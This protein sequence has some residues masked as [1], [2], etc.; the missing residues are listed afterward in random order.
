ML[1]QLRLHN[2][3]I[4]AQADVTFDG[5]FTVI[6]GETGSG[7]SVM[8]E[9]IALAFGQK[10]SPK[11][12][13]RHGESRGLVELHF[14]RLPKL[15]S[16]LCEQ[17]GLEEQPSE[18]L[19]TRE[20]S[21]T[22]SRYRV[23]G[24][25]VTG[26]LVQQLR[27]YLVDLHGQHELTSLFQPDHHRKLL[28][29]LGNSDFQ[30]L[31]QDYKTLHHTWRHTCQEITRLEA[32]R[33]EVLKQRDFYQFQFEALQKAELTDGEEDTRLRTQL[34]KLKQGEALAHLCQQTENTLLTGNDG[35]VIEALETLGQAYRQQA[36]TGDAEF[37]Q[38]QEQLAAA[39]S[40]LREVADG[41]I[42]YGD[43]L[44]LTAED[45]DAAVERLDV[46]ERIRR[47]FGPTLEAAITERD[48]LGQWLQ[49][50]D[51]TNDDIELLTLKAQKQ[52]HQL[53]EWADQ[54]TKHRQG[55]AE[56]LT[57]GIQTQLAELALP[58][59][60]FEVA[61]AVL[62]RLEGPPKL[63]EHGQDKVDFTFS[64]N[65]GE[66]LRPLQQVASGG[67]LSRVLLA[68]KVLVA[69]QANVPTLVFDEIDTGISGPTARAVAAKLQRMAET[70]V[71]VLCITHQP[72]VA[73]AGQHHI[74]VEKTFTD[75]TVSVGIRPLAADQRKQLLV[76]LTTGLDATDTNLTAALSEKLALQPS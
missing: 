75:D 74:H 45:L 28:D 47:K 3:A 24:V 57:G 66:P 1:T 8:I 11:S 38:F 43:S 16:G 69:A 73:A 20:F 39:I 40:Q 13:L 9:S 62:T 34:N 68:L 53:R 67:E 49:S 26:D 22:T 31:K 41:V 27:P 64:A 70:G 65:P 52:E 60:T 15:P 10:V 32:E 21:T 56:Q 14:S 44:T 7:K 2:I 61:V 55:L 17:L 72:L 19:L 18:L 71:Q 5:G 76:R 4:V 6:T 12:I 35:S 48:R 37:G 46:L 23:D 25:P 30:T 63:T 54:L 36:A 29:C 59:A 50:A 33:A 42:R 58:A 51:D